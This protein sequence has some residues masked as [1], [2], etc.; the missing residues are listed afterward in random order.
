MQTANSLLPTQRLQLR[1]RAGGQSRQQDP[2][3]STAN[4]GAEIEQRLWKV[5]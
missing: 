1:P 2:C 3:Q 5:Y 4:I